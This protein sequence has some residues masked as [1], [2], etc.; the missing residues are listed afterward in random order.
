VLN[1]GEAGT[2]QNIW[3]KLVPSATPTGPALFASPADSATGAYVIN[4]IKGGTYNLIL[5][6]NNTL[7]DVTPSVPTGFL[8][9]NKPDFKIDSLVL[10]YVDNVDLD[11][12]LF[13]GSTFTAE[14]FLDDGFDGGTPNNGIKDGGETP[15]PG[16]TIIATSGGTPVTQSDTDSSGIV[17]FWLPANLAGSNVS[18]TEVNPGVY[19]STG[20]RA[21]N[22]GGTY[23][24][25]T[26]TLTFIHQSGNDYTGI[27]FGD[28]PPNTFAANGNQLTPP[29]T[30]VFYTHTFKAKTDG[31]VS[32][33]ATG[34][35]SPSSPGWNTLI[36]L[37][38]D[39]DGL[40]PVGQSTLSAPVEATT[41][42]NICLVIKVLVPSGVPLMAQYVSTI[43]ADFTYTNA[44]PALNATYSVIDTTTIGE[45]TGLTLKKAVDKS[46]AKPGEL[47]KYTITYSN[48]GSF[49][50]SNII[51]KDETP[52]AST[53]QSWA[54]GPLPP[55][56]TTITETVP[57]LGG[58]GPL[59]WT[60]GGSLSPGGSGWITFTV[61]I[62]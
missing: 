26:D 36:Y 31:A 18:I 30:P 5:S 52:Y 29:A 48:E 44:V 38:E 33:S 39:C 54:N 50:I 14:V 35:D 46:E 1:D 61:K 25:A 27:A 49:T 37:D 21:G 9:T 15:I 42:N 60:I 13:G 45:A 17:T 57:A 12:G 58:T 24:R 59:R 2:G 8:G 62:E 6:T 23:D 3:V 55:T 11:F 10:S 56:L 40:I 34:V 43:V 16:V 41:G 20:A 53:F 22:T 19:L 4:N 7:A 28:V 51:V 47:I 32:F